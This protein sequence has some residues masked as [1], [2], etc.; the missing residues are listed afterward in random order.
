MKTFAFRV[1]SYLTVGELWPDGDAPADPT[2]ADARAVIEKYG[3]DI[4]ELD[5]CDMDVWEEYE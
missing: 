1:T 2:I 5:C 4:L 3:V